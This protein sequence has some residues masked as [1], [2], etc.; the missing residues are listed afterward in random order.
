[1]SIK[2]T[3][4]LDVFERELG[5]QQAPSQCEVLLQQQLT[6]IISGSGRKGKVTGTG[7]K[8][9]EEINYK[10]TQRDFKGEVRMFGDIRFVLDWYLRQILGS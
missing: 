3:S 4:I 6:M 2:W 8:K 10:R 7:G 5:T 9:E 1:M